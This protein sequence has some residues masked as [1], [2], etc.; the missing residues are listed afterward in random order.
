MEAAVA[1]GSRCMYRKSERGWSSVRKAAY[2][3]QMIFLNTT[4]QLKD[5]RI[6]CCRAY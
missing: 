6:S 3:P 2:K 5:A 4:G 1:N